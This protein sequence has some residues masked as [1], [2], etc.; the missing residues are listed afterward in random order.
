MSRTHLTAVAAAVAFGL[1]S[2]IIVAQAPGQKPGQA[3]AQGPA[4]QNPPNAPPVPADPTLAQ[5]QGRGGSPIQAARA[6]IKGANGM[7]GTAT[8]YEIANSGNGH[9]VQVVLTV[10]NAPP[11]MHACPHSWDRP[12]RRPRFQERRRPF[13]SRSRG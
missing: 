12:V 10:Q 3:P 6:D 13:R 4:G 2:V 11:G 9:M 8:L 1:A 5:G 7:T